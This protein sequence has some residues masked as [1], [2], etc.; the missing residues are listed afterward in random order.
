MYI[1]YVCMCKIKDCQKFLKAN[2]VLFT[3][4][5]LDGFKDLS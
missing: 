5:N 2:Y 1:K 3:S 4:N